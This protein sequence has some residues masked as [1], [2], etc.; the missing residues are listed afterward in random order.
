M[1]LLIAYAMSCLLTTAMPSVGS[2][3][4]ICYSPQNGLP[5]KTCAN[6]CT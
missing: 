3:T 6:T 2:D 5:L 1:Q 4:K